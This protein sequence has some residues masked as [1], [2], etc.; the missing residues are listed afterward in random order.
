MTSSAKTAEDPCDGKM[1]TCQTA[2]DEKKA[3]GDTSCD[4]CCEN[5]YMAWYTCLGT[6]SSAKSIDPPAYH[7]G[8]ESSAR[9]GA[10][11][12]L[13]TCTDVEYQSCSRVCSGRIAEGL[14]V[15][16]G[17]CTNDC[18]AQTVGCD[19]YRMPSLGSIF[20][21]R[22]EGGAEDSCGAAETACQKTCGTKPEGPCDDC[23]ESC[24][25]TWYTCLGMTSSAKSIDPPAYHVG[26]ESSAKTAED[27]CDGKMETCQTACDEKKAPGDTSC[28]TCC[29]NCYMAWYTCLG[30]SSSAKS[31]DPPAYHVGRESSAKTGADL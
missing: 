26:R 11:L 29:E 22:S 10:D 2:C 18:A 17:D 24:L 30:T 7:V 19:T 9:T 16:H 8:R 28:D 15:A 25:Q 20:G 6:S 14:N 1:E 4:T 13:F 23:C 3:P 31:I 12:T 27:P 21:A 5:C